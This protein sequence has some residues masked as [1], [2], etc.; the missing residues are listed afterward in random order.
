M[1]VLIFPCLQVAVWGNAADQLT[2]LNRAH[3]TMTPVFIFHA[4]PDTYKLRN[5]GPLN[6]AFIRLDNISWAALPPTVIRTR[7]SM[8]IANFC[9]HHSFHGSVHFLLLCT[10]LS[11]YIFTQAG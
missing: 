6:A 8:A 1:V 9:M 4:A 5:T 2:A 11:P 10:Y 7:S 3:T